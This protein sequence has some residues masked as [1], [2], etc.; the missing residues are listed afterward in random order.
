MHSTKQFKK[1]N[2]NHPCYVVE[3]ATYFTIPYFSITLERLLS[4][5]KNLHFGYYISMIY[6]KNV[7][8]HVFGLLNMTLCGIL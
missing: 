3:V 2:Y 7:H 4:E 6:K 1:K 5:N 8:I